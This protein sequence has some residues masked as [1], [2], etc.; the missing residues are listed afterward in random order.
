MEIFMPGL[1]PGDWYAGQESNPQTNRYE[2]GSFAKQGKTWGNILV[3]DPRRNLAD[4][5]TLEYTREH[6]FAPRNTKFCCPLV[7][8][9]LVA[10]PKNARKMAV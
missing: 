8:P 5:V 9:G 1:L 3:L 7:A 4:F 10:P 6:D 2:R